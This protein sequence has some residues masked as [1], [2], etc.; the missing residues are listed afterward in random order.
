MS[1]MTWVCRCRVHLA[2]SAV[3]PRLVGMAG[4]DVAG[5][6]LTQVNGGLS[7][8]GCRQSGDESQKP[9]AELG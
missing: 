4:I 8:L 6:G 3:V 7:H 1:S 9:L 2:K 5:C